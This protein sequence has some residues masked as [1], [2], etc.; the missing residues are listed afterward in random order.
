MDRPET[1]AG[2]TLAANDQERIQ[3]LLI[4]VA[5][6]SFGGIGLVW[7]RLTTWAL[8]QHLLLARG[9]SIVFELPKAHGA[10][11]DLTRTLLAL[12]A[13]LALVA[14]TASL[15]AKRRARRAAEDVNNVR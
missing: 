12:A 1:G 4:A 6:V 11:L 15:L 14:L 9:P 8:E 7:N 13:L 10:G 3:L 2:G 5:F